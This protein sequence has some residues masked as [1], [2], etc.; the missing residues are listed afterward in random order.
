MSDTNKLV[1]ELTKTLQNTNSISTT[2]TKSP[3]STLGIVIIFILFISWITLTIFTIKYYHDSKKCENKPYHDFC[4]A[5]SCPNPDG[6]DEKP[7]NCKHVN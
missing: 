5:F 4:P 3:N 6:G 1:K 7:D 2:T